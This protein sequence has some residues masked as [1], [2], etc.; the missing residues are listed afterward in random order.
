MRRI[1]ISVT[2]N[3]YINGDPSWVKLEVT[4]DVEDELAA[5]AI[6]KLSEEVNRKV[7]DVVQDTVN[8]VKSFKPEN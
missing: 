6:D 7:L 8:T 4:D 5:E 2:H 3:I 1:S